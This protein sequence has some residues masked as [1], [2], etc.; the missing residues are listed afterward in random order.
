MVLYRLRDEVLIAPVVPLIVPV[1]Q[2]IF[3]MVTSSVTLAMLTVASAPI[4]DCDTAF[5]TYVP[6]IMTS[7][8]PDEKPTGLLYAGCLPAKSLGAL[9]TAVRLSPSS[10]S[11]GPLDLVTLVRLYVMDGLT[12]S[13]A[14]AEITI[15]PV[16][17]SMV[18]VPVEESHAP[19]TAFPPIVIVG[20]TPLRV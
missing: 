20:V 17:S 11:V 6:P 9:N 8:S 16:T 4:D 18:M 19:A 1:A 3:V 7:T 5:C 14:V 13:T 15:S 10:T 2:M 12:D